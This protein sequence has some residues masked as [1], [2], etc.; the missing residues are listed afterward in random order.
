[1]MLNLN[2]VKHKE[3]VKVDNGNDREERCCDS[4]N[5]VNSGIF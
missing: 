1:M 5:S 4:S 3:E 2:K